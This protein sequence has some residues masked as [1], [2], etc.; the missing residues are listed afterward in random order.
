MRIRDGTMSHLTTT[1]G[2]LGG[3][4]TR[5]VQ[6]GEGTDGHIDITGDSNATLTG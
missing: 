4:F 1:S 5:I 2:M 6:D 3:S